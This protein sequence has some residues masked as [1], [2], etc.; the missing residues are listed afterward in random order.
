MRFDLLRC[1]LLGYERDPDGL[2][3]ARWGCACCGDYANLRE[4]GASC[5]VEARGVACLSAVVFAV[6]AAAGR[7]FGVCVLR[8]QRGGDQRKAEQDQQQG[9]EDSAHFLLF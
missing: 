9:C 3:S 2:R 4:V 8:R 5:G 1:R 7:E 6:A